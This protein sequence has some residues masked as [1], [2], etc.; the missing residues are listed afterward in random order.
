MEIQHGNS[1]IVGNMR[2]QWK[3]NVKK[4]ESEI[5]DLKK[6]KKGPS[7]VGLQLFQNDFTHNIEVGIAQKL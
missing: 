5:L 4:L 1:K 2:K 3:G 7:F 6:I